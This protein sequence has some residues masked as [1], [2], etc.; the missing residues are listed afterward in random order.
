MTTIDAQLLKRI[1]T[2][3][4]LA[5]STNETLAHLNSVQISDG[6]DRLAFVATN[7]HMLARWRIPVLADARPVVSGLFPLEDVKTILVWLRGQMGNVSLDLATGAVVIGRRTLAVKLV[8]AT[9]P[10][11]EAVIPKFVGPNHKLHAIGL[12]PDCVIPAFQIFSKA[13]D[14]AFV[15]LRFTGALDPIYCTSS[16][17]EGLEVVIMPARMSNAYVAEIE[18]TEHAPAAVATPVVEPAP[19]PPVDTTAPV[20]ALPKAS[21]KPRAKTKAKKTSKRPAHRAAARRGKR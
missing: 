11:V 12:G 3:I 7:G 5:V 2:S 15:A 9:F 13:D 8:D 21:T 6:G 16:K 17:V 4:L 19:A 10:C 1:L 18:K 14:R 20:A